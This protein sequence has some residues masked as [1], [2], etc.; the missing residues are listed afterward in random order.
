MSFVVIGDEVGWRMDSVGEDKNYWC[1]GKRLVDV[2]GT[3]GAE[4]IRM[5]WMD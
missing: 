2:V 1:G 3:R 5:C 4:R